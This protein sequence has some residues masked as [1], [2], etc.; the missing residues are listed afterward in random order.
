MSGYGLDEPL[1]TIRAYN[2][3]EDRLAG[4][5]IGQ[6]TQD[7]APQIFAMAEEGQTVFG[8]RDY[9]FERLNKKP[10]D[11]WEMPA[12]E[13]GQAAEAEAAPEEEQP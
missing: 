4:L 9:V 6:T 5:L 8:L 10:A 11:F 1:V 7:D 12:T 2:A 13:D 3:A